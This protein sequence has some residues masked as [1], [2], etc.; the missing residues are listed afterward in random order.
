MNY[1][2]KYNLGKDAF[3]PMFPNSEVIHLGKDRP[4]YRGALCLWVL[5]T[6]EKG[7]VAI[8]KKIEAHTDDQEFDIEGWYYVGT[9]VSDS[10]STLHVFVEE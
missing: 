6:V 5:H 4:G 10:G 3:V 2:E 8:L 1:I 7:D 9:E